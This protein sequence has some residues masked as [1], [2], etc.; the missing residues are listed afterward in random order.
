MKQEN[1]SLLLGAH[2]STSGGLEQAIIKGESIGCTA[3]GMFTKS[4]R[5]WNARDLTG[6]E[7]ELFKTTQQRST[8]QQVIAHASYLINLASGN[9]IHAKSV[10]ALIDEIKRC[11]QLGIPYLVLHPGSAGDQSKQQAL[12]NI[13][14]GLNRALD[15]TDSSVVVLLE[16]MAGQGTGTCS[17]FE[18]LATILASVTTKGRVAVCFDT[19]HIF[20]AGYDITTKET[21]EKTWM[22][23]DRVI[24]LAQLKAFHIND[25]LKELN[26]HVDRH[27]NIGE[28]KIGLNAFKLLMNDERFFGVP[29]IIET[30]KGENALVED[31]KN[32]QTLRELLSEK[33]KELL[34]I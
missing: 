15:N 16:T 9:D 13:V 33:T 23:F 31:R 4:N 21:Y 12:N 1:H 3:I 19:C 17:R 10:Q 24:G 25:S 27:A 5:Q 20:A 29:K 28:G 14:A 32:L 26:S 11:T 8:V 2:M 6:V 7:I 22:E 30:P 34:H 18:E